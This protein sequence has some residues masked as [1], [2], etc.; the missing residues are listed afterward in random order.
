MCLATLLFCL[1]SYFAVSESSIVDCGKGVT[2]FQFT[3]LSLDPS[4]PVSGQPF[5]LFNIFN[6]PGAIVTGGTAKTSV[7][8]NYI[9]FTPSVVDLCSSTTCPLVPGLNDKSTSSTWPDNVFGKVVSK[10]EWAGL[11][12]EPLLCIQMSVSLDIPLAPRVVNRS[13]LRGT[14][15]DYLLDAQLDAL[16]NMRP[17]PIC[18]NFERNSDDW[19]RALFWNLTR[20]E[21]YSLVT[22]PRS[23]HKK[24]SKATKKIAA[25]SNSTDLIVYSPSSFSVLDDTVFPEELFL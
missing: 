13:A 8:V 20:E 15:R 5:E 14:Y 12:A 4:T 2:R 7:S 9:P 25:F 3:D 17:R 22:T 24:V 19:T 23:A 16:S 1:S 11:D 10:V 18:K 6:N 21:R